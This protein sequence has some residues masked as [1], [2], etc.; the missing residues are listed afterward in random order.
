[1]TAVPDTLR[2]WPAPDRHLFARI[3]AGD[4][5][6]ARVLARRLECTLYAIAYSVLFDTEQA[7][8]VV[9]EVMERAEQNA[10]HLRDTAVPVRH[11]LA[12]LTRFLAAER[13]RT[14]VD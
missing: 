14:R 3:A 1:M 4:S 5:A 10:A 9:Q 6:A 13:A 7:D 11:W 8:A 2:P 12:R